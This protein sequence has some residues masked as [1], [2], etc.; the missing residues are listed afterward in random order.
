MPRVDTDQVK[1]I[2]KAGSIF[3][4]MIRFLQESLTNGSAFIG[5]IEQ[6]GDSKY[7]I[8]VAKDGSQ[9]IINNMRLSDGS[10]IDVNIS[11][12][13]TTHPPMSN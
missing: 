11:V 1:I 3:A 4:D 8:K 6:S 10:H 7:Y 5:S 2:E 9:L 13:N 12:E